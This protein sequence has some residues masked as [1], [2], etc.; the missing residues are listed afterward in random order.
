MIA[1]SLFSPLTMN[2]LILKLKL[3]EVNWVMQVTLSI[4]GRAQGFSSGLFFVFCFFWFMKTNILE[5]LFHLL[6][7]INKHF[8]PP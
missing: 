2:N 6:T 5:F 8:P 4:C 3:R 7:E 1:L